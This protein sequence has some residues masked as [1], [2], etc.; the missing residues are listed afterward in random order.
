MMEFLKFIGESK[1]KF[2]GFIFIIMLLFI[3]GA[4]F[5]GKGDLNKIGIEL[6]KNYGMSIL[7]MC[8]TLFG[9]HYLKK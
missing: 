6:F 7:G 8:M 9:G 1:I 2:V 5:F 4:A 3:T